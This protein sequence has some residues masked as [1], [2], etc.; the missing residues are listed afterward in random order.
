[1]G[2]AGALLRL[3]RWEMGSLPSHTPNV[4]RAFAGRGRA[5]TGTGAQI[6]TA[7]RVRHQHANPAAAA[8]LE[9]EHLWGLSSP[10]PTDGRRRAACSRG[11]HRKC[12]GVAEHLGAPH[13]SPNVFLTTAP[14]RRTRTPFHREETGAQGGSGQRR[15]GHVGVAW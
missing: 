3:L 2:G 10:E 1:M 15:S 6:H 4:P 8:S 14:E 7:V 12:R 5:C 9:E 13:A 11:V